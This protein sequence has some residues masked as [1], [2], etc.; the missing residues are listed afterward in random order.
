[1]H[2]LCRTALLSANLPLSQPTH[3]PATAMERVH[4]RTGYVVYMVADPLSRPVSRECA[5]ALVIPYTRA[6]GARAEQ[7]AKL[8]RVNLG[9]PFRFWGHRAGYT[10]PAQVTRPGEANPLRDYSRKKVLPLW[11]VF[12]PFSPG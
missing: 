8:F 10:E 11:R 6:L 2:C 7:W 12:F 1:M 5:A 9:P 4:R 3:H